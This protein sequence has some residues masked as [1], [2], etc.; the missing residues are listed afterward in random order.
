MNDPKKAF[1]LTELLIVVALI[2][3]L[4]VLAT[5][6]VVS[7]AQG[8]AMRKAINSVSDTVELARI[9]AMATS[10]WVLVGFAD[11]TAES[12]SGAYQTSVF[13]M[14]TR[15]GTT[16]MASDNLMTIARPLRLDH[17]K[18]L[19]ESSRWGTNAALVK[20][21]PFSFQATLAGKPVQ[22][23]DH[24]LAFSPRGEAVV[25]PSM[26]RSWFEIP[27]REVHGTREFEER[28]ASVRVS[29]MSGQVIVDY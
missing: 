24:I 23:T 8:G 6:A 18:L 17:V 15:D 1:S 14:A 3:V 9:E 21:S 29:G 13:V 4:A 27:L 19:S 12:S 5:P 2:A 25:N 28:T 22:V 11:T 26:L 10:S 7:I 20:G 16:N